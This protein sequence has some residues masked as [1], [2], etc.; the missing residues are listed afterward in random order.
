MSNPLPPQAFL[1]EYFEH[2]EDGR[3]IYKLRP[4]CH[5]TTERGYNV[6][7]HNVGKEAG[8]EIHKGYR[9][10][11]V[12]RFGVKQLFLAH[13]II[14]T[15]HHGEIPTNA[16]IDHKD[17]NPFNNRIGNLRIASS[18]SNHHN[19]SLSSINTS[20]VKGVSW[21]KSKKRWIAEVQTN[22][23]KQR[24]GAYKTIEE[25]TAAIREARLRLHGE[26]A[27]HGVAC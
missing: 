27:N 15:M 26:F 25:A 5:F 1:C 8:T 22:G 19:Q 4:R 16:E 6:A 3:L 12:I 13:R 21:Y 11:T 14:W 9:N 18:S 24:V 23:V 7:K 2:L 17:T 20:G 10:V